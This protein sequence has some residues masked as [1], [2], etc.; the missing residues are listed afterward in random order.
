M[1]EI[2]AHDLGYQYGYRWVFKESELNI[3]SGCVVGIL[4]NNGS[5]KSTLLRLLAGIF[6]PSTG[7]IQLKHQHLG[8]L[9]C[10]R[11]YRF[12]SWTAPAIMPPLDLSVMEVLLL[13]FQ[14]KKPLIPIEDILR[15]ANLQTVKNQALKLLSSGQLQRLKIAL[16][17]FSQS[18][19]MILDE[20]STNLDAD[21]FELIWKLVQQFKD[22]RTILIATND[23]REEIFFDISF[24][25]NQLK[26][27]ST[28][29]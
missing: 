3:P 26:I 19:Y 13:H 24:T 8:I 1:V 4:G 12:L 27:K 25:I 7:T 23:P 15:E 21:N 5:G 20:P 17:V 16:A 29:I 6:T 28:K 22:D 18:S 10:S 14:L 2:F 11:W 9:E